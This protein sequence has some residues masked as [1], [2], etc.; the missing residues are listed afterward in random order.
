MAI[1]L[2]P[3][4]IAREAQAVYR[5][6]NF[7]S[8]ARLFAAAESGYEVAQDFLAAA[9]M[10][11]NRSVALLQAGEAQAALQALEGRDLVFDRVGDR[12]RQA[13][14][15]GNQAAA[16]EALKQN[17]KAAATYRKAADLFQQIGEN[18][19]Y[20]RTM[21]SLS[22]IQLK[23]FQPLE[24]VATMQAGLDRVERLGI[25]QRLLKRL[26]DLPFRLLRR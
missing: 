6:G 2:N 3:Q 16:L 12:K 15:W 1:P 17:Q 4:E 5:A 14:T 7:L 26:L 11:N 19:L 13:M 18:E 9:K 23:G 20:T 25:R 24:A 8:A 22:L 10:A 21:Q